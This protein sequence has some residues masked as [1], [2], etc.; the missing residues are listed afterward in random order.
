MNGFKVHEERT[1]ESPCRESMRFLPLSRRDVD[2]LWESRRTHTWSFKRPLWNTYC[3]PGPGD[4][5]VHRAAP[6]LCPMFSNKIFKQFSD[7]T[8]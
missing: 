6:D 2:G 1:M 4:T 7:K 8:D 3:V 5:A